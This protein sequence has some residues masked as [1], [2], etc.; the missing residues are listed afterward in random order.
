MS[1]NVL[2]KALVPHGKPHKASFQ[3]K[4]HSLLFWPT[5]TTSDLWKKHV[6][7]FGDAFM[8]TC[9]NCIPKMEVQP[10]VMTKNANCS[11]RAGNA[12][13]N[14]DTCCH[15][16]WLWRVTQHWKARESWAKVAQYQRQLF[17]LCS[18]LIGVNAITVI[19]TAMWTPP[20]SATKC[21]IFR[22]LMFGFRII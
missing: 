4:D 10:M 3:I 8:H 13:K 20:E 11:L 2:S 21:S 6:L 17:F 7:Y 16:C 12:D 14:H 22:A 9:C 5:W 19:F 1:M 15:I 18:L